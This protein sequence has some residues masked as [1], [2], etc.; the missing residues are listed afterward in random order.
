[1]RQQR[2]LLLVHA[3][4]FAGMALAQ[5]TPITTQYLFNG[6]LINPAYA[7][8]R[9]ALTANLTYRQQ[10][11][12]FD[13]APTTQLLSIH[14][15]VGGTKLGL[16]FI[17]YNDRIGVSRET[18]LMT[19]YA[20]R[21]RLGKGKLA[22]GLGAGLKVMQA[23]WSE[24]RTTTAGDVEFANDSRSTLSPNFS[25][26]AYYSDQHWFAGLSLPFILSQR[27]DA[28]SG[29]WDVRND[30]RQYQPMLTA[31]RLV[32]LNRDL[33]LKP[34]VL[35]RKAG[36]NPLQADLNL[37][38][39]WRSCF[40]IGA[41]YRTM[42]AVCFS[43]EVLPTKQFRIGYA[44]DLGINALSTYHQG[45]HEVMLQYEFGYSVHAKDPRYF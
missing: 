35:L 10:W 32:D 30:T 13:G 20:Y 25:A 2:I 23:D 17:I 21:M 41:S 38:L 44:Y 28:E 11:V 43:V 9:E 24:V 6:L 31:G 37:N 19:N 36:G 26:G 5:H 12:G 34:S 4:L 7:G 29:T 18:G 40:W 33:K 45:S 39:I 8:S 3:V 42:D 14:S 1:M 27:Y 22:M 15:P 16:G